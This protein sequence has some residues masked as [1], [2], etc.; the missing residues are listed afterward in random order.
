ML[1]NNSDCTVCAVKVF[2]QAVQFEY[3]TVLWSGKR[4]KSESV[5]SKGLRGRGGGGGGVA[6]NPFT[7]KSDQF[8]ISPA[9]SPEVLHHKVWR[10]CLFIAYSDE[11]WFYNHFSLDLGSERVIRMLLTVTSSNSWPQHEL[12]LPDHDIGI[13]HNPLEVESLHRLRLEARVHLTCEVCVGDHGHCVVCMD[14]WVDKAARDLQWLL[15]RVWWAGSHKQRGWMGIDAD[16][17]KVVFNPSSPSLSWPS[18]SRQVLCLGLSISCY[19][20]YSLLLK[21]C[22]PF[23]LFDS[24]PLTRRA[25]RFTGL[26]F[27][28]AVHWRPAF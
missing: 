4:R 14:I 13:V 17:R 5:V 22:G 27:W 8:Q 16:R 9:A 7:L 18:S 3:G 10:T 15:R 24:V 28:Q 21:S 1:Q 19:P 23:S 12:L 11:R 25:S 6:F 2:L 20:A 26:N